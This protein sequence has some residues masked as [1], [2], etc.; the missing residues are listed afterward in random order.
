M[1]FHFRVESEWRKCERLFIF[2]CEI[3]LNAKV[4][5]LKV[6]RNFLNTQAKCC[7]FLALTRYVAGCARRTAPPRTRPALRNA[8]ET[9]GED[10]SS[11]PDSL[12][13]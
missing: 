8:R 6:C 4:I 9:G 12:M 10:A 13:A 5:K 1:S 7:Q 3:F 11:S 2:L